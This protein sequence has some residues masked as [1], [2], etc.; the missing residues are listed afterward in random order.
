MT[1]PFQDYYLSEEDRRD[2]DAGE[3]SRVGVMTMLLNERGEVLLTL[4]DDFPQIDYPNHW[5]PQG[6]AV[7]P[8]ETPEQAARRELR[9]EL[10]IE[11]GELRE[12]GRL[13]DRHGGRDLNIVFVGW[14]SSEA[15][16]LTVHEG[17]RVR[18]FTPSELPALKIS[19][20]LKPVLLHYFGLTLS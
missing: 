5:A 19:P 14:I 13:I 10:D 15:E 1:T 12:Y 11:V 8:G 17:Q 7:E 6:G 16:D 9:E 3:Y 4:R 18:F 20:H 2:I